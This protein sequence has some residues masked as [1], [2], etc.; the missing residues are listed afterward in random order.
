MPALPAGWHCG[1]FQ[2]GGHGRRRPGPYREMRQGLPREGQRVT[3][4]TGA[5]KVVGVNPLVETVMVR[6][7]E[8]EAMAEFPAADVKVE[9]RVQ[10]PQEK[11]ET[12]PQ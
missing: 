4:A 2:E 8:S 11:S 10:P 12:R 5:G 9:P 6:L 7:D 1:H 3:T